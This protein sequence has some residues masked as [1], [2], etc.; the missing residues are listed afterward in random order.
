MDFILHFFF[1]SKINREFI[2]QGER[3]ELE[4]LKRTENDEDDVISY[5]SHFN[6]TG[7]DL[8]KKQKRKDIPITII[9]IVF[10]KFFL[11]LF[12]INILV[13]FTHTSASSTYQEFWGSVC[14]TAGVEKVYSITTYVIQLDLSGFIQVLHMERSWPRPGTPVS[15][16]L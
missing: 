3:I 16:T 2:I 7:Y 1:S 12:M 11:S 8:S 5:I 4:E 14:S 9:V 15:S 6:T 13:G 10:Y